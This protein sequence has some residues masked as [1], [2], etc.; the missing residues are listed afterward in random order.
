ME[1]YFKR[2]STLFETND[3]L[4]DIDLGCIV[5]GDYDLSSFSHSTETGFENRLFCETTERDGKK[6]DIQY[7]RESDFIDMVKEHNIFAM[8]ALFQEPCSGYLKYFELDRWKLRQEFS[9]VSS[10]S[11][12]KAKKKM[13]VEKDLDMRCGAKSLFHSMRILMFAVQIARHG[14]I[15][16]YNCGVLLNNSIMEDLKNGFG[17]DDFN[18]KYKPLWKEWHHEMVEECPKP[19]EYIQEK[20][21]MIQYV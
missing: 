1:I 11:W 16:H 14:K 12:V 3:E 6:M 19:E 20:K 17:W 2:G 4:S 5:D 10:N 18:R 8:E 13:T 15:T 21:Q 9:G 7:V